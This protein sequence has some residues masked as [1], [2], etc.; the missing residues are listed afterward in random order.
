MPKKTERFTNNLTFFARYQD[1]HRQYHHQHFLGN[2][3][4]KKKIR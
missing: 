3:S 2:I 1:L 4:P